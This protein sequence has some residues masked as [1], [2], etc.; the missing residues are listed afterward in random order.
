MLTIISIIFI[1]EAT[2]KIIVMGFYW[3]QRTYLKD[4]WNILDFTLVIL[5]I[6]TWVIE[7]LV[8]EQN[9]VGF[10]N[11]FRALRSL[12]PLRVVS[13]NEG[14]KT[15][16]NSLLKAIPALCNV[17]LVILLFLLVFGILGV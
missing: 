2:L 3:G 15:V 9:D 12:R 17:L 13:K 10:V 1:I 7:R 6:L 14:I 5:T 11:G 8:N 4:A 16:V